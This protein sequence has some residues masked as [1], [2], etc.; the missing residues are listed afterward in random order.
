MMLP[1]ILMTDKTDDVNGDYILF[2]KRLLIFLRGVKS[3]YIQCFTERRK[4]TRRQTEKWGR[5]FPPSMRGRVWTK[6]LISKENEAVESGISAGVLTSLLHQPVYHPR[7]VEF[8][9]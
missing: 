8:H 7:R 4:L 6:L 3:T 5:D 2:F 9:S 1:F